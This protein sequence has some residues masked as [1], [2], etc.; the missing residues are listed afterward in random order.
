[1]TT[2]IPSKPATPARPVW[3]QTC[4]RY[5]GV[6]VLVAM[7]ATFVLA[8]WIG[9]KQSVWFD[10]AYSIS[11]IEQSWSKLISLTAVDVHPPLYY[12]LLK[13]WSEIF[14]MSEIALR[15]F[16]ALCGAGAVGVGLLVAK[17]LFGLRALLVTAP[18]LVFS[19]L[20]LRYAFEIRMYVLASL[21]GVAATY[22]LVRALQTK[23]KK[24]WWWAGYSVLVALGMYTLYYMAFVWAAHVV[25]LI[26]LYFTQNSKPR[27]RLL[28]QPWALAYIGAIALYIPW[29]PTFIEQ[30]KSPAL[31]GVSQRVYW[32]QIVDTFSFMF[33][34]KPHWA[35]STAMYV[36]VLAVMAAFGYVVWRA[37]RR[38]SPTTKPYLLLLLMY[39]GV[40]MLILA[41][42]SLPPFRPLF[43]VRYTSHFIIAGSLLL[44]ASLLI[45]Y[46]DRIRYAYIGAILAAATMIVGVYNL[47]DSGNFNYETLNKP[48]ANNLAAAIAP[49]KE[50]SIVL[51][52][53]ALWYFEM[54]FY[55]PHCDIWFYS[56]H[57]IGS[58]GGYATI[59]QSPKQYY[60]EDDINAK[61][62]YF[63]YA[64]EAPIELPT[65]FT[66]TSTQQFE[67]YHLEVYE[68]ITSSAP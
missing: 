52:G 4:A 51:T 26:Y 23:D 37:F 63:V 62:V 25:W 48:Q 15:S 6:G 22:V 61:T 39:F 55:L 21:I 8:L 43:L 53:S 60:P 42:G 65:Q 5:W 40:P 68:K 18:L 29:I 35:L 19:P 20:L 58:G 17:R 24:F 56:S 10:E 38:A 3:L 66:Q 16:G 31:S 14:G 13:L 50:D 36:L 1:M 34:Y 49:C 47:S 12:L 32:D 9:A 27:P 11:L 33:S 41:I 54:K 44:G 30:Y 45:A 64:G 2:R 57:P 59:Y 67:K 28:K 7:V 46:K